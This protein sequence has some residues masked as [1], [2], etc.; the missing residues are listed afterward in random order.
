MG[1]FIKRVEMI[2]CSVIGFSEFQ[3]KELHFSR[4]HLVFT[5]ACSEWCGSL[6]EKRTMNESNGLSPTQENLYIL[7]IRAD[8]TVNPLIR[9]IYEIIWSKMQNKQKKPILWAEFISYENELMTPLEYLKS[10]VHQ[11]NASNLNAI[12]TSYLDLVPT[13]FNPTFFKVPKIIKKNENFLISEYIHGRS[14]SELA[15]SLEFVNGNVFS[16]VGKALSELNH[17]WKIDLVD[18]NLKNFIVSEQPDRTSIEEFQGS[19]CNNNEINA[20][21]L[22][23]FEDA[24]TL[25]AGIESRDFY[26]FIA[27]LLTIDNGIF[28]HSN[29]NA[30]I[31]RSCIDHLLSEFIYS[32]HRFFKE[33]THDIDFE[34]RREFLLEELHIIASRRNIAFVD[35]CF[36]CIFEQFS[37]LKLLI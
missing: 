25:E 14:L 28:D 21:F 12:L 30:A 31:Y 19:L 36:L 2:V 23:D 5:I 11:R 29:S 10:N 20:I 8:F 4:K 27:H 15:Y 7:K 16:Q 1:D 35:E 17:K 18:C 32:Y 24:V 6:S 37:S 34:Y 33:L 13:D 9:A 26:R 3:I 22:I